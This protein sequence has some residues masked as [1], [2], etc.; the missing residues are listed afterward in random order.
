[1]AT[2]QGSGQI[3]NDRAFRYS[4]PGLLNGDSGNSIRMPRYADKTFQVVGT[5]GTG[6][7][8]AVKGSM[9]NVNFWPLKDHNGNVI[10][11]TSTTP[12]AV[13]AEVPDYIQPVVTAGDGTTNLTAFLTAEGGT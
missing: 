9:D 13:V 6:G 3:G 5:F 11:L 4:W 1:M 12:G 7:S 10:A 8:V 2:R